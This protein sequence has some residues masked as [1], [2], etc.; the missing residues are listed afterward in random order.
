[1]VLDSSM[2]ILGVPREVLVG[3]GLYNVFFRWFLDD[4][5]WL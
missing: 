1:M 2:L 5:R 3:S 4:S